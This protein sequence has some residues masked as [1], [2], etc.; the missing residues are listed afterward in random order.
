MIHNFKGYISLILIIKYGLYSLCCTVLSL[1]LIY[2]IHSCLYLVTSYPYLALPHF[3]LPTEKYWFVF[4]E[5]AF[6]YIHQFIF[7]QTLHISDTRQ[8]LSLTY[9]TQSNTF[10]PC[11]NKWQNFILFLWLSTIH[12]YMCQSFSC[13]QLFATLWTVAHQ[14]SLSLEF[15]RQEYRSGLPFSSPEDLPNAG[16][17][18]VSPAFQADSLPSEPPG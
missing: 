10:H 17:E 1:Q 8:Y 3:P 9:F 14:A 5:S 11:C 2:F 13:I 18:P 12:I 15:S 16:T 6:H 7:F 4:Y